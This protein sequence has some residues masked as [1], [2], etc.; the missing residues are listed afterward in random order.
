MAHLRVS[1]KPV[2]FVNLETGK[3]GK[4]TWQICTLQVNLVELKNLR[5]VGGFVILEKHS[6]LCKLIAN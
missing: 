2:K 3:L 6:Q 5:K 1:I 4:T